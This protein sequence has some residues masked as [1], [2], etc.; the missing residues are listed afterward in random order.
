[1]SRNFHN[2]VIQPLQISR[3]WIHNPF[4][5]DME[6]DNTFYLFIFTFFHFWT[7]WWISAHQTKDLDSKIT[8]LNSLSI[9]MLSNH[10][11]ATFYTL[12]V[13]LKLLSNHQENH[14]NALATTLQLLSNCKENPSTYSNALAT[15]RST[16]A[17][18]QNTVATVKQNIA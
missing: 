6:F 9:Y 7:N 5:S 11:A 2:S 14:S 12:A 4:K 13:A 1:M 17:T 8:F 16:L 15:I 10:L 3:I 18:T